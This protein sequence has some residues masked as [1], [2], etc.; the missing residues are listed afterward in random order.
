ERVARR[1]GVKPGDK[2]RLG[3]ERFSEIPRTTLLAKRS[4]DDSSAALTLTVA[5]VLPADASGNDFNLTPNP[6]APLHGFVPVR[7]LSDLVQND[8]GESKTFPPKV[9][10]LLSSGTSVA[11]LNAALKSKLT[12]S[13]FGLRVRVPERGKTVR[14]PRGFV[15]IESEQLVMD[16]ATAN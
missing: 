4:L 16:G 15:S 12:A 10:A 1:L 6:A 8:A 2:V 7:T 11:E 13:D 9:T 3:V 5:A 14:R